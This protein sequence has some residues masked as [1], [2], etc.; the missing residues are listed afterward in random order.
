MMTTY[1]F[2][3]VGAYAIVLFVF[4]FV[5]LY[6]EHPD[7]HL[8]D[9]RQRQM[10]IIDN[11]QGADLWLEIIPFQ[12]ST[13]TPNP[14]QKL[15]WI[16]HEANSPPPLTIRLHIGA[17]NPTVGCRNGCPRPGPEKDESAST[18]AHAST[19]PPKALLRIGLL[20]PPTIQISSYIY[21]S[22]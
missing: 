20:L 18:K 7:L 10:C 9:R 1:Y 19:P 8:F 21:I 4:F 14:F 3:F 12:P 22:L 5:L 2:F 17:S 13:K 11:P 15:E 6:G 16:Q